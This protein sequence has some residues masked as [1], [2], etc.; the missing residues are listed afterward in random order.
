MNNG[1][2]DATFKRQI[3]PVE[4]DFVQYEQKSI[5]LGLYFA[6]YA[7]SQTIYNE[8]FNGIVENME[9]APDEKDVIYDEARSKHYV[10]VAAQ[11]MLN[12]STRRDTIVRLVTSSLTKK[13]GLTKTE[14]NEI[15]HLQMLEEARNDAA[16]FGEEDD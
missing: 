14:V 4:A 3:E 11:M 5:Q 15:L 2:S 10:R 8:Q 12:G 1:E 6:S 9:D 13:Y 7:V 16:L